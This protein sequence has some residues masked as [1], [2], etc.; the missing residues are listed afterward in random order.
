VGLKL[1]GTG[2][3][4]DSGAEMV[5]GREHAVVANEMTARWWDQGRQAAEEVDRRERELGA[6]VAQRTFEGERDLS[7]WIER[8]PSV[9]DRRSRAITA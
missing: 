4:H 2:S 3:V 1:I 7:G 9:G 5:V 8:E 6:T